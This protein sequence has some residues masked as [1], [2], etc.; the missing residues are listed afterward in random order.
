MAKEIVIKPKPKW[1]LLDFDE[2]W[3]YRE[4]F[5]IF[6]WRDIKVRY[7]QTFIGIIWVLFQPIVTT[8]I[9]T[10]FFGRLAQIPS[11]QLPYHLFVFTGLVFWTY[12]SN[13]LT[14]ASN[15][16]IENIQILK[17]VYF[18]KEILPIS[19]SLTS[20]LDFLINF[21]F[22]LIFAIF[23]GFIPHPIIFIIAPI[24]LLITLILSAGLGLLLSSFN[25]KYRDV[26]YILPFFIQT[27]IFLTPVIYPS[28]TIRDSLRFWFNLNPLTGILESMRTII[29]GSSQ[30]DYIVLSISFF[31]SL[32]IF[33]IGLTYFKATEKFFADIA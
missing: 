7:K 30:I 19:A 11:G 14:S 29:S 13:S 12:F 21:I 23:L 8:F 20:T 3:R 16:L 25:V 28:T 5:F 31:E 2:L 26:R 22:L 6:T 33:G 10:M 24:C 17:K 1:Q 27:M 9:F 4:L 15:S 32:V 18:P